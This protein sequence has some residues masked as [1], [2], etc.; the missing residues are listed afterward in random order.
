VKGMP[1]VDDSTLSL[2]E[3][4]QK[5]YNNICTLW[6]TKHKLLKTDTGQSNPINDITGHI[7]PHGALSLVFLLLVTGSGSRSGRIGNFLA[8]SDPDTE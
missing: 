6:V 3:L 4:F 5:V 7:S 8:R 2:S 1:E